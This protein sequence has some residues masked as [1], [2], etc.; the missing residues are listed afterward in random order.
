MV[1]LKTKGLLNGL[2]GSERSGV[3]VPYKGIVKGNVVVL[4]KG[5]LS[6]RTVYRFL[7]SR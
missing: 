5:V 3:F 2:N 4:E 6:Y 7:W 1:E